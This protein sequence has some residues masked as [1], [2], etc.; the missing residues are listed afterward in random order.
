ME[1]YGIL[2]ISMHLNGAHTTTHDQ[3]KQTRMLGLMIDSYYLVISSLTPEQPL[4]VG[5]EFETRSMAKIEP[6]T[7]TRRNFHNLLKQ[8]NH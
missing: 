3:H 5:P 6:P 4:A 8:N 1:G 7:N 2:W